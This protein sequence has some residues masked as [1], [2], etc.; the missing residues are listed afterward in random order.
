VLGHW[1]QAGARTLSASWYARPAS[2]V[3][4]WLGHSRC[5]T[6]GPMT[7]VTPRQLPRLIAAVAGANPCGW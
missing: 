1:W 4:M 5:L 3:M 6:T 2:S 7:T